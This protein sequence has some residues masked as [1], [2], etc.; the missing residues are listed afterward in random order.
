VR[1]NFERVTYTTSYSFKL[2]S[3]FGASRSSSFCDINSLIILEESISG[4]SARKNAQKIFRESFLCGNVDM[5]KHFPDRL[6][7]KDRIVCQPL[8]ISRMG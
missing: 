6:V 2:A 4:L 7:D 8:R 1:F 3:I 5:L